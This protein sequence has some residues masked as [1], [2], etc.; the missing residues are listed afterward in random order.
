MALIAWY[1]LN[2]NIKNHGIGDAEG[3]ITT[4]PAYTNGKIGQCLT[5]GGFKWTA[6]Q[7]AKNFSDNAFSY[8]C[9][10]YIPVDAGTAATGNNCFF[11]RSANPRI[12]SI[13]QY[14]NVDD[15]HLS[16]I[17]YTNAEKTTTSTKIGCVLNDFFEVRTWIHLAIT[18]EPG[19]VK[20][21][22]NG[23][24]FDTR[25]GTMD[26]ST[27]T[28]F[29]YETDII[30]NSSQRYLND[31]RIYDECLSP[32]QVK[33]ISKGLVAHYK[34][35]TPMD[36]DNLV[37]NLAY[38]VYNN[39]SSSGTTGSLI[40]L[41]ERYNNCDVY[42]LTMTPNET[43]LSSFK[44]TLHGHGIYGFRKVFSANTKYCF[45]ILWRPVTHNDVSVGGV[46]SNIGGW[47][48]IP[49]QEW[50]DGWYIV[51]QK[52][53]GNVTEN[54]TDSIFTSFK[55]PSA[56]S[57]VP[58]SVDFCCPHLVEGYDYILPEF[59]YTGTNNSYIQ[60][61]SGNGYAL[62]KKGIQS[63]NTNS[64]RYSGST[65]LGGTC[66]DYLYRDIF[67]WLASP[68]TFNCWV[69]QTSATSPSS[70][71][72]NNTIQ[73][74]M[75]QGRDCGYAGFALCSSNGYA[76]LFLGTDV[77]G[78]YYSLNDNTINLL[79]NWH[80]LTGTFDG[81]VAKLY[82]DGVQKAIKESPVDP[83]WEQTTCFAIGK[84]SYLATSGTTA[85]FPFVGSISDVRIYATA[86]SA[87]EILTMYKTSGIIDNKGN[88][89]AYELKEE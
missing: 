56:E 51:G 7:T 74:I 4:T 49:S 83:S 52:R 53:T 22:K 8:C 77:S 62:M 76:R 73:F 72:E 63:F 47:T 40:K 11:G 64:A 86:L 78:T 26:Y 19:T 54:K 34:L 67:T 9:W 87:D 13:F 33:E 69:Y 31:V 37:R 75:N 59:N 3:I 58:I 85:Y 79:N 21:Y 32:K 80:M 89:Y 38:S 39:F 43:S 27:Y 88:I 10:I 35:D 5:T 28:G 20:I 68:F 50:R 24:L 25:T 82:V 57:G 61:C 15:L 17:Q 14:P 70:G 18:Y 55:C 84:M 71:N 60:D 1:P 6:T 12:Y 65:T 16:W 46:A 41:A 30:K 36:I 48:E 2:G 45:W 29:E 44:T 23:E 42:R 66:S 81:S